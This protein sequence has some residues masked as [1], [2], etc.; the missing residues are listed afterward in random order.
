MFFLAFPSVLSAARRKGARL[1]VTQ[2]SGVQKGELI[3]VN[4][5]ALVL[6]TEG[7]DQTIEVAQ[8]ESVRIIKKANPI[9]VAIGFGVAGGFASFGLALASGV[10]VNSIGGGFALGVGVIAAGVVGGA[11]GGIA[12][13]DGLAK[14]EVLAFKGSS[15][16]EVNEMLTRLRG[17]ARVTGYR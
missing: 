14:D 10:K 13:S 3:G 17:H 1:V 15:D 5:R 8:I 7:G 2:S 12:M 16:G 11:I 4:D 6:L 9:P